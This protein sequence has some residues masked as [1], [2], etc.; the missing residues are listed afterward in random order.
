MFVSIIQ[1]FLQPQAGDV[2][3]RVLN[4]ELLAYTSTTRSTSNRCSWTCSAGWGPPMTPAAA[5][6]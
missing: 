6:I 1:P 5:S 3:T 4:L 2:D